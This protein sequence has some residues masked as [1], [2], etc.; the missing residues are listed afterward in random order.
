MAKP[1]PVLTHEHYLNGVPSFRTMPATAEGM[2]VAFTTERGKHDEL[3][4]D[5]LFAALRHYGQGE[6][7][8]MVRD[9]V[10]SGELLQTYKKREVEQLTAKLNPKR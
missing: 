7:Y 5:M 3:A 8:L 4:D 6:A 9:M 10:K 1:K 2:C